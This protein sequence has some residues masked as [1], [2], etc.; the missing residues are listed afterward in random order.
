[1]DDA[2]FCGLLGK[3]CGFIL[4]LGQLIEDGAVLDHGCAELP[5]GDFNLAWTAMAWTAG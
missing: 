2:I 3:D 4:R 5:G 1:M